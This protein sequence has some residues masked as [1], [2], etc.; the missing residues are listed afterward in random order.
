VHIVRK[1]DLT[2]LLAAADSG[3]V[4]VFCELLKHSACVVIVIKKCSEL[5]KAAAEKNHVGVVCELLKIGASVKVS[6]K[7]G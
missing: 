5:L 2:A 6:K 4:E 1:C 7:R 3:Q